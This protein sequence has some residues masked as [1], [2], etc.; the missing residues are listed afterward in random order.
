MAAGAWYGDERLTIA[1]TIEGYT[2]G[3]A[4]AAGWDDVIGTITP[5]KLADIV[6]LDRDLFALEA[7]GIKGSEIAETEVFMTLFDGRIIHEK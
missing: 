7:R 3:A 4:K 6:A 5:G 2:L 1:Q